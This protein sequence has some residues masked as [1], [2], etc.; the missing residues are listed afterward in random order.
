MTA[1]RWMQWGGTVAPRSQYAGLT[2]AAA[3]V[4]AAARTVGFAFFR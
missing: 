1:V 4:S 2:C 3:L